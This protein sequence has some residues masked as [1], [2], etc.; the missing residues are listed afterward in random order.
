VNPSR[1]PALAPV[2]LGV[3]LKRAALASAAL[4]VVAALLWAKALPCTFA[5]V[6]HVPC[7]GC[8][9]TRA[10]LALAR[11]DLA[12]VLRY[13]PL[14]P[15]VAALLAVFGVQALAS[16]L[17]HGDFRAVGEGRVGAVASR[18]LVLVAALDVVLW[19][20]RFFGALGGPVPV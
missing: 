1:P 18:A 12:G 10:V 13:N 4:G 7:P 6:L 11:G 5:R 20:A 15:A 9:S 2:A 14:G 17:T 16:M 19:A 8:G 3:R